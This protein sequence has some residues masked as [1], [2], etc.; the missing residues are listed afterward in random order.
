MSLAISKE[1]KKEI[2]QS[3]RRFFAEKL[4]IDLSEVQAGFLI[5]YF[6]REIAPLAYNQGVEDAQRY[7]IRL[8]EDLPGT[9]FQEP[10][11]YWDPP[12]PSHGV[13]RKPQR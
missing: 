6:F 11:T 1:R 4:E 5:E 3:T 2:V 7:L 13:R 10:L 8:A 9:C 12:D